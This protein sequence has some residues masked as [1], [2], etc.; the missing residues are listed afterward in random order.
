MS[1]S[2]VLSVLLSLAYREQPSNFYLKNT[3]EQGRLVAFGY[4]AGVCVLQSWFWPSASTVGTRPSFIF[5]PT[6]F[7]FLVTVAF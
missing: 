2:S 3:S 7:S 6:A 5:S 4:A 1:Q